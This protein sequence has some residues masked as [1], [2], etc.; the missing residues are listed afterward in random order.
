M[1]ENQKRLL[2]RAEM[3]KHNKNLA[4]VAKQSGVVQPLD[5]AIFMDHGYRGLY[6]GLGTRHQFGLRNTAH[7]V[8]PTVSLELPGGT[9][10]QISPGFGI[11]SASHRF[12]L[13]FAVAYE[14][15]G[16]GRYLRRLY[17]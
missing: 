7:Y 16:L 4:G 2:L 9:T 11:T 10:F 12:L 8:A 14:L 17:R 5:Y 15:P 1:Q 3:K 6:G 13:R